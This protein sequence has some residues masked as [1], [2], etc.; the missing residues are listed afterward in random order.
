MLSLL[1]LAG[2]LDSSGLEF[3]YTS[4]PPAL[5][6]GILVLG[7]LTIRNMVIPPKAENFI[8]EVVCPTDCTQSVSAVHFK[9]RFK[10]ALYLTVC[11]FYLP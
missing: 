7:H 9:P 8:I 2:V 4:N 10:H 5:E 6:A 1:W 11:I 3:F